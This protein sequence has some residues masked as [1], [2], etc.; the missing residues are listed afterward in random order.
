MSSN[1]EATGDFLTVYPIIENNWFM[2]FGVDDFSEKGVFYEIT[3]GLEVTD[4]D[5]L[6]MCTIINLV[7]EEYIKKKKVIK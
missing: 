1:V 5:M 4:D 2:G 7:L 6:N 3:N